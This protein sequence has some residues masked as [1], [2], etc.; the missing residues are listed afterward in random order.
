MCSCEPRDVH[1]GDKADPPPL[2]ASL[3]LA[4]DLEDHTSL[5]GHGKVGFRTCRWKLPEAAEAAKQ[6]PGEPKVTVA[7]VAVAALHRE[8]EGGEEGSLDASMEHP[9][10]VVKVMEPFL[11]SSVIEGVCVCVCVCVQC[12]GGT[13]FE[14]LLQTKN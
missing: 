11:Y 9:S 2:I 14:N 6:L 4:L 12:F 8:E 3:T 5:L 10:A 7:D 13:R 1:V